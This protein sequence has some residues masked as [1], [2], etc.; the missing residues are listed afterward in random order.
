ARRHAPAP[1]QQPQALPEICRRARQVTSSASNKLDK[2][3]VIASELSDRCIMQTVVVTG[4]AGGIGTRLRQL[5]PA[6]YP[7]IRWSDRVRPKGLAAHEVFVPADLAVMSEVEAAVD[8]AQGIVH[9][10][11]FSTEGPWETILQAN[12]IGCYNLFEAARRRGVERVVFAS[13]NH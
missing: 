2:L 10:G 11:G 1:R 6:V 12:I 8:G 4:A 5:L 13:S 3:S 9:L 7:S